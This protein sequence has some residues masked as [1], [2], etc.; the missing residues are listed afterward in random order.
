MGHV[1][2]GGHLS[3]DPLGSFSLLMSLQVQKPDGT[4]SARKTERTKHPAP[5]PIPGWRPQSLRTGTY[6]QS[7]KIPRS[8][9]GVHVMTSRMLI[10]IS[11]H[12]SLLLAR[13]LPT[14]RGNSILLRWKK[15]FLS[16]G[17]TVKEN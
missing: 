11:H 7:S 15:A 3:S 1:A 4:V 17:E 12:I 16:N 9:S 2:A 10:T 14:H 8:L 5:P 6:F 13:T